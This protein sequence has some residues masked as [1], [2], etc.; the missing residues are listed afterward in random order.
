M[1]HLLNYIMAIK[2]CAG[3]FEVLQH[4]LPSKIYIKGRSL[5]LHTSRVMG[6]AIIGLKYGVL[7]FLPTN[8]QKQMGS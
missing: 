8:P 2:C 7:G 3:A 4:A 1:A 5:T 6:S